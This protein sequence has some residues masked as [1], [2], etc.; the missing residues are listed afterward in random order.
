M[1]ARAGSHRRLGSGPAAGAATV[2]GFLALMVSMPTAGAARTVQTSSA[3]YLGTVT[4]LQS[5]SI[6]SAS[7][8]PASLS[9]SA[10]PSFSLRSG[11]ATEGFNL[12]TSANCGPMIS[13]EVQLTNS[14]TFGGANFSVSRAGWYYGTAT[15]VFAY[16]V[17]A[18]VTPYQRYLTNE[19][20]IQWYNYV[21]AGFAGA[22]SSWGTGELTNTSEARNVSAHFSA[23]LRP[24]AHQVYLTFGINV[25]AWSVGNAQRSNFDFDMDRSPNGLSLSRVVVK[26]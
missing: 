23:Y 17:Q 6:S 20:G 21:Q 1:D 15:F 3:P 14:V 9:W 8:A 25:W 16:A 19:S 26:S 7:C 18:N 2:V 13:S 11:V 24:G 5:T 4:I 12:S 10:L 22:R